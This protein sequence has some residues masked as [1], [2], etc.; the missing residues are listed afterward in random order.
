MLW[1]W[2]GLLA[3]LAVLITVE[4]LFLARRPRIVTPAEA[5]TNTLMWVMAAAGFARLT[6]HIYSTKWEIVK[7]VIGDTPGV[8]P[9]EAT[10]AM[11][12]FVTVYLTEVALSLDNI[13]ILA[14]LFAFY[15][16]P[17]QLIARVLFWGVALSL[18]VRLALIL[19]AGSLTTSFAWFQYV[20]AILL[21]VAMVRTLILPD[22]RTNFNHLW[23]TR[24]IRRFV[25]VVRSRFG[26]HYI[27]RRAG[28]LAITPTLLVILVA[29]GADFSYTADFLPAAFS[30]TADPFLAFAGNAFALLTLRSLFFSIAPV[31]GRFRFLKL[32]LVFIMLYIAVKTI[33]LKESNVNEIVTLAVVGGTVLAGV[34]AS[35]LVN[36]RR[37]VP[38]SPVEELRPAPIDDLR[39]AALSTQR[40]F[41]K[42]MILIAGTAVIIFGL[43]IAPLPGPGPT[44][45]IPIGIAIL[46]T[47]FIWAQR[48]MRVMKEQGELLAQRS[49]RISRSIPKW[50]APFAVLAWIGGWYALWLVANRYVFWDKFVPATAFGTSF[51]FCVWVYRL[52][53]RKKTTPKS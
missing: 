25:P 6:Y 52:I 41:R 22:M 35:I 10:E 31:M 38:E 8:K 46:G 5:W 1:L 37:G 29:G 9:L 39:E 17:Q 34:L 20:F 42:V 30:I 48:L 15:K 18:I 27:V 13:A 40:N 24:L 23:V 51:P 19:L 26:D 28:R 43:I 11:L 7:T 16:I 44:V 36:K 14:L 21:L 33:F 47:E 50:V 32:T 49:D 4:F 45:L 53:R 12:Q 2:L 3:V